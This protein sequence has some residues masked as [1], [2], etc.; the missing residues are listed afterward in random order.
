VKQ[1]TEQFDAFLQVLAALDAY[2]VEYILVGGVAVIFHGMERLTRDIDVF[3]KPVPDNIARLRKALYSIFEDPAIEEITSQ[4]LQ[5]Y[6]VIRYG[7]PNDF[8]ID[9]MTQLG[10]AITYDDLEHEIIEY[11]GI[12][13]RIAT[14]KTLYDLKNSMFRVFV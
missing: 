10:Q 9:I 7:T 6:P 3:V 12:P 5:A 2:E 14:P 11:Q 8:Y 4:E 13:I 1:F